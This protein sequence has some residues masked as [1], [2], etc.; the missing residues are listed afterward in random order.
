MP[1]IPSLTEVIE[2]AIATALDRVHVAIPGVIVSYNAATQTAAVAPSVSLPIRTLEGA[3]SYMALPT[4]PDV[5]VQW[6]SGGGYFVAFGLVP[7]DPVVLVFSD[8]PAGE[9]LATGNTS[10]PTDTRRHS[11]GY[12]VAIPG[13]MRPDPK[14]LQS[15]PVAGVV[16]GK[17]GADAQIVIDATDVRIGRGA[18][19]PLALGDKVDAN[20]AAI[21]TALSGASIAVTL[22][23]PSTAAA[24]AKGK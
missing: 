11:M 24:I 9:Y 18:T 3:P 4:I 20:I 8:V 10:D 12:P 19:E 17:D 23:N 1:R 13:G 2:A 6:P 7:G 16:I 15:A 21:V 22:P 14:A 5:P